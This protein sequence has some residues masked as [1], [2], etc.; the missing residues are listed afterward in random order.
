M[1]K[2]N[3]TKDK[4]AD[5]EKFLG[6]RL[7]WETYQALQ[8]EAKA[9]DLSLSHFLR[10]VIDYALTKIVNGNEIETPKDKLLKELGQ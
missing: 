4:Q 8:S 5:T 10:I 6:I 3:K 2:Q 7:P 9:R 1:K